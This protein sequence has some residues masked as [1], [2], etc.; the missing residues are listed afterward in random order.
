MYLIVHSVFIFLFG[1][2]FL[3]LSN[4]LGIL[5]SFYIETSE[6]ILIDLL[7]H[8]MKVGLKWVKKISQLLIKSL[9]YLKVKPD[10]SL[11]TT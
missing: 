6:L 11:V 7:L 10:V 2:I 9:K 3:H 8:E 4:Q 1:L 5:C